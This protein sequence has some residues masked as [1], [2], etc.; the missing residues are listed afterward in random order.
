MQPDAIRRRCL[1][2]EDRIV[3]LTQ[4]VWDHIL[5][6]HSELHWCESLIMGTISFPDDRDDD[7]RPGRERYYSEAKGPTSYFC[8]VVEY[9]GEIGEVVTAFGH[10][11]ER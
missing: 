4:E 7:V 2:P 1:D 9:T 5:D 11:N 8:V 3:A 10:R 6:E